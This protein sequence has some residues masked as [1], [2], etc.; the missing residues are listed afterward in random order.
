[1]AVAMAS[2]P[3]RSTSVSHVLSRSH[4]LCA[5]D[6]ETPTRTRAA[7]GPAPE[8]P[9]SDADE[10]ARVLAVSLPPTTL[11]TSPAKATAAASPD[12]ATYANL[13]AFGSLTAGGS[14]S[15]NGVSVG[16]GAKGSGGGAKR[17]A[18]SSSSSSEIEEV[19]DQASEFDLVSDRRG[20]AGAGAGAGAAAKTSP[21]R[22]STGTG[23]SASGS[24]AKSTDAQRAMP[25]SF[26]AGSSIRDAVVRRTDELAEF[27]DDQ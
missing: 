6:R 14:G 8:T 3:C 15:G 4:V 7:E 5:G 19:E 27:Y 25:S 11:A 9:A 21:A 26:G 13:G 12:T 20:R 18:L 17:G 23:S 24:P 22:A 10:K 16:S 2:L 1:M